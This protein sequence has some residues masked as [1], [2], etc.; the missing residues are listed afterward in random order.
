MELGGDESADETSESEAKMLA[1]SYRNAIVAFTY[2]SN[3]YSQARQNPGICGFGTATP[4]NRAKI[5]M[6]GG[7]K[8]TAIKVLGVKADIA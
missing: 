4:Q 2:G 6:I 3:S 7:L 5:M 8:S 1:H